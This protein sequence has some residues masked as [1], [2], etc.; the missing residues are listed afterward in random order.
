MKDVPTL[1]TPALEEIYLIPADL[2]DA[3]ATTI[4]DEETRL[5][6]DELGLPIY[7]G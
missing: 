5:L 3:T 1:I 4:L 6:R 2:T 7:E